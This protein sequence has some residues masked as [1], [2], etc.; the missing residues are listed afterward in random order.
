MNKSL[1]DFYR[2][3]G[4]DVRNRKLYDMQEWDDLTLETS[5]DYIQWMFPIPELSRFNP[6]APVLDQSTLLYFQTDVKIQA[7][8]LR[9]YHRM[10]DFYGFETSI[11]GPVVKSK[12]FEMKRSNWLRPN[13]HN[14]LRITRILRC[15]LLTGF[16][17]EA[18]EFFSAL[19]EIRDSEFGAVTSKTFHFWQSAIVPSSG[20]L[21]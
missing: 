11:G 9:S 8:L 18:K 19:K 6:D 21:F 7:N 12:D 3:S 2:D 13:N 1:I 20:T 10:L 17:Q 5:H 4:P 15:L 16:E 14:H